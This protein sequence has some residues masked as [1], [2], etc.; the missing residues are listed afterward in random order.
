MAWMMNDL[1]CHD[2]GHR[3]YEAMYKRADGPDD[4]PECEISMSVSLSGM[5]FAIHGQGY[6][7]FTPVDFGVLGKA[8]TKEDYDRCVKT[9]EDRFPGKRV[10]IEGESG[11]KKQE[12]LDVIRHRSWKKKK[13]N[14]LNEKMVK[15]IRTHNKRLKA[16]GRKETKSASQLAKGE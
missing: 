15:E 8:E 11:K 12:R 10:H 14:S 4:C 13:D 9:I 1:V 5:R 7:S 3:E 16:E 6:G 2:C